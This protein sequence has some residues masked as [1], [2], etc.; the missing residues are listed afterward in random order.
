MSDTSLTDRQKNEIEYHKEHARLV[1]KRKNKISFDVVTSAD[2][3]LHNAY[4]HLYT[5]LLKEPLYNKKVLV[6]G[7]GAGYDALRVAKMGAQVYAFDLSPDML[8]IARSSATDEG[9]TIK[10]DEMPAE[11]LDYEDDF[12]DYVI[13]V[14]ILHHVNIPQTMQEIKR[15][16]KKTG[17][18]YID[19]IYSHSATDLIRN[20]WLVK[21][22]IY[23]LMVKFIYKNQKPYITR[24]ERKLNEHDI[25]VIT[26]GLS[27]VSYRRY[28]NFMVTRLIPDEFEFLNKI[29]YWITTAFGYMG[30]YVAGRII[31][32]G[33]V[34]KTTAGRP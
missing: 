9:F 26:Q 1:A 24:D 34:N 27:T 25:D 11:K 12:F 29:D 20:S 15:V 33:E 4:W 32:A 5:L 3:R 2:R 18:F 21:K 22:C 31:I 19:E 10:F 7:C 23:P 30:K 13:A 28:F 16:A 8:K 17:R 14:D 6:V